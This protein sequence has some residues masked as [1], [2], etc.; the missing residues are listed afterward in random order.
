MYDIDI[1]MLNT[2]VVFESSFPINP[3]TIYVGGLH[4]RDV[5]PLPKD[6]ESWVQGAKKGTILITFGSVSLHRL[7]RSNGVN[8][9]QL[10]LFHIWAE[11]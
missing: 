3:N 6:L 8:K 5:N 2:H 11:D 4:C 9:I 7:G 10:I 1:A